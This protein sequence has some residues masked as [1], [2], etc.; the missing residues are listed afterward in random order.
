[1]KL[2][3]IAS[4]H[5]DVVRVTGPLPGAVHNLTAARIWGIIAEPSPRRQLAK[6]IR[7]LQTREIGG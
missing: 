6:A 1:M 5:G 3:V 7:V 2:Q 4:P